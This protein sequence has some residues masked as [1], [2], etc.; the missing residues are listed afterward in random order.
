VKLVADA[1]VSASCPEETVN[2][3]WTR[4]IRS[5]GLN[6]V[7]DQFPTIGRSTIDDR[8]L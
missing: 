5:H 2:L 8:V 7:V 1:A 4:L 6:S 3:L